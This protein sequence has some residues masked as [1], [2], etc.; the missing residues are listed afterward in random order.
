MKAGN[1]IFAIPINL[2]IFSLI[3]LSL[4]NQVWLSTSGKHGSNILIKKDNNQDTLNSK[5]K[6]SFF[7]TKTHKQTNKHTHTHTQ[8]NKQASK[9]PFG[10]TFSPVTR[11]RY[12]HSSFPLY[13]Y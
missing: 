1:N 2:F 6:L 13:I 11:K 3:N 8:A 12:L 4:I 5:I 10:I 7:E 9:D